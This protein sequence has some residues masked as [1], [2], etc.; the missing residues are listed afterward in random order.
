MGVRT[1]SH[2]IQF[3]GLVQLVGASYAHPIICMHASTT[4]SFNTSRVTSLPSSTLLKCWLN[5]ARMNCSLPSFTNPL[6]F[7]S[8]TA[9]I[10]R[11][12]FVL[13]RLTKAQLQNALLIKD[14][15]SWV[16]VMTHPRLRFVINL[17]KRMSITTSGFIPRKW[18]KGVKS[19]KQVNFVHKLR[20]PIR[21]ITTFI[22][23][24]EIT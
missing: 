19:I 17:I 18:W 5:E 13:Q 20:Q 24:I 11:R 15:N 3:N 8:K 16:L 12:K 4:I 22:R 21:T 23:L 14:S 9:E 7:G 2:I 1:G 10:T 6:Q